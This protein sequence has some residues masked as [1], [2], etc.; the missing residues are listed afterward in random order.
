M[1][2]KTQNKLFNYIISNSEI[3]D[4]QSRFISYKLE[5]NEVKNITLIENTEEHKFIFF[6][7]NGSFKVTTVNLPLPISLVIRN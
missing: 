6:T 1:S 5:L 2:N 3:D 4:I 7:D